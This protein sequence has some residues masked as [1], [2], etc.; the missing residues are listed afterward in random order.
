MMNKTVFLIFA[1]LQNLLLGVIIFLIFRSLNIINGDSVIG[2][3][4]QIFI[5]VAFP[6]FSLLVKY[7]MYKNQ[8]SS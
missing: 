5:S 4:T 2:L 8:Q 7:M 1:I 3:D 6:L